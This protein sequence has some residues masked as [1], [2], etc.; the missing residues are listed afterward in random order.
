M[1][2]ALDAWRISAISATRALSK[3]VWALAFLVFAGV[4]MVVAGLLL[5][6]FG[7]AGGFVL[8]FIQAWL[9]GWYLSLIELGVVQ[10]RRISLA[11]IRARANGVYLW[12]VISVMF[13]FFIVGMLLDPMQT[14]SLPFQIFVLAASLLFNTAPEQIY[15]DH[16]QSTALL[17]DSFKFMQNKWPEWLGIQLPI[18]AVLAVLLTGGT[19]G[20][21]FLMF[22]EVL[23]LY[24]PFF[25]FLSV[26][27]IAM[28]KLGGGA[29]GIA[30]GFALLA[31]SHWLLLF[32]GILYRELRFS[33]R[34]A[35]EWRRKMGN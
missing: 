33:S 13:I 32:R 21:G 31:L 25:N 14:N 23:Q 22:L 15:Q 11:D 7:M 17:M 34:R 1:T 19:S 2:A 4:V 8:G 24:G 27:L 9:I 5:S 29:I 28:S 12:E 6:P 26:G 10:R 35:R 30:M 18:F 3:S 20:I 16:T